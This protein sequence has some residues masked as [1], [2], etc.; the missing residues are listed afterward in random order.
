M[1]PDRTF[2]R[3]PKSEED[4]KTDSN[5]TQAYFLRSASYGSLGGRDTST[6][7]R[8]AEISPL[9]FGNVE[10][11]EHSVE[12]LL[13]QIPGT[14]N[15]VVTSSS[16]PDVDLAG[17]DSMVYSHRGRVPRDVAF[18]INDDAF[19]SDYF[20]MYE[21]KVKRCPRA[22]PHDWTLC[23]FAH[24]GEKAKRR[25]PRICSYTGAACPDFRKGFCKRGDSCHFA[26][27]VFECW[28]HPSR[29]R[30]QMCTDGTD[31]KRR[32][33]FFAHSESEIRTPADDCFAGSGD[34]PR[35]DSQKG[36][37]KHEA[38]RL[39]LA[40][41]AVLNPDAG[42]RSPGFGHEGGVIEALEALTGGMGEG[43]N[44]L[45][46]NQGRGAMGDLLRRLALVQEQQAA[47]S[48][49][50]AQ[51]RLAVELQKLQQHQ[52][53]GKHL[54]TEGFSCGFPSD[55][56]SGVRDVSSDGFLWPGGAC[57]SPPP[58]AQASPDGSPDISSIRRMFSAPGGI[59]GGGAG[60]QLSTHSSPQ[61]GE[62]ARLRGFSPSLTPRS[63]SH[64]DFSRSPLE[65]LGY[66][67]DQ[68]CSEQC[69]WPPFLPGAISVSQGLQHVSHGQVFGNANPEGPAPAAGGVGALIPEG[70]RIEEYEKLVRQMQQAQL[71]CPQF[72]DIAAHAT[73]L[74]QDFDAVNLHQAYWDIGA[75]FSCMKENF[76]GLDNNCIPQDAACQPHG[77]ACSW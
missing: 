70:D 7:T 49:A 43:G 29:Y 14:F 62:G 42:G 51:L 2:C 52:E 72:G 50:E 21:F 11:A 47:F 75:S 76:P 26:H 23:P 69:A 33:C 8:E 27:G 55:N 31:C 46:P 66:F 15:P 18:D 36:G 5:N 4:L 20:R 71:T 41:S 1:S 56:A 59:V 45:D 10:A 24:P 6:G 30:T 32:V 65:T 54:K 44:G 13:S 12:Y 61:V 77:F 22:R 74:Q 73:P 25:D 16:T 28:L 64:P 58:A 38:Q 48:A 34:L 68:Q 67:A 35:G 37:Q 60:G 9:M 53:A 63:H 39:A 57:P 17:T 40:L 19:S 3:N